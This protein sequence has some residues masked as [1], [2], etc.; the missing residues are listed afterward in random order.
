[1]TV[2]LYNIKMT[3][4]TCALGSS[5]YGALAGVLAFS[6][7]TILI[8][9]RDNRKRINSIIYSSIDEQKLLI[10]RIFSIIFYVVLTIILGMIFT[11]AAQVI[12]YK[13]PIHFFDYIYCYTVIAFPA[14]L[15]SV[16]ISVGLYLISE[17]IDI[18]ILFMIVLFFISFLSPN[19]LLNWAT[20]WSYNILRFCRY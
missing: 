5:K 18:S 13:V 8:L 12:I 19:Y 10:I 4:L 14:L 15:F 16:F 20:N 7:L 9:S 2:S 1:M 3:S 11:M 6:M 17:S